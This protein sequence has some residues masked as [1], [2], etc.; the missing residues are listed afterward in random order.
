MALQLTLP[1]GDKQS[2]KNL[3]FSILTK[4]YPLKLI[5]LHN[6]IKKRYGRSTT[7]QATRKAVREL[8]YEGV[9]TEKSKQ[10]RINTEWVRQSKE[11][12]DALSIELRQG[13]RKGSEES[14]AGAVTVYE[15]ESLHSLMEFWQ[16]LVDDWVDNYKVGDQREN[17]YQAHHAWEALSHL[18]HEQKMMT[19]LIKKGIR[20]V[21]LITGNTALDR[22]IKNFYTSIGVSTHIRPSQSTFDKGYHVG[23]YGDIVVHTTLPPKLINSIDNFFHTNKSV[24][25]LNLNALSK[26]IE[27]KIPV[28]LTVIKDAQMAKHIRQSIL[29]QID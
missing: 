2:I 12:L 4:E 19:R 26:I 21:T 24:E 7:Y 9:L 10:Y 27:S 8:V 3:V 15:F 16:S 14:I 20:S 11:V 6:L 18:S 5:E 28:K 22:S 23:T 25:T 17:Y 1:F 29:S 13:P